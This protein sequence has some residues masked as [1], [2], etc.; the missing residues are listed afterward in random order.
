M[1]L[2]QRSLR[3]MTDQKEKIEDEAVDR[4]IKGQARKVIWKGLLLAVSLMTVM[5]FIP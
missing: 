1:A 4:Q 5:M 2:A 3:H